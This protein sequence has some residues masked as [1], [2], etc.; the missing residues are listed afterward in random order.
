VN[1]LLL[2]AVVVAA[3]DI[4]A[5]QQTVFNV[6]TADVLDRGKVYT[7]LDATA[8]PT[9]GDGT[10]T[11]RV[12]IGLGNKIEVGVNGSSFSAPD[13]STFS[14]VPTLKWKFAEAKGFAAFAGIEAFFPVY[15]RGYDAGAY[16]YVAV[17]KSMHNTRVTIGAY[18]FTAHVVD[19]GNR[20]GIQAAVEQTLNS[21]W[22]AAADWYS[23]NQ[24]SGF[25]TPGVIMKASKAVTLYGGY[26]IG[27]AN[28]SQGN[29]AFLFEIG[30]NL[31]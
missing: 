4:C 20:A 13:A 1:A 16:T 23:G 19:R 24:A 5:A 8:Q 21:R 3:A 25:F 31:N 26:E 29:H 18:D 11:P 6:P 22:T 7:E 12:V 27:N 28:L 2:S 14:F 30:W 9:P 17:A 10:F 15:K